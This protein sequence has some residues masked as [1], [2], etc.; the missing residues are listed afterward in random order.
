MIQ[1]IEFELG[2]NNYMKLW[3]IGIL[4][5]SLDEKCILIGSQEYCKNAELMNFS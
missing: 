5:M 3:N 1:K 2:D 4:S